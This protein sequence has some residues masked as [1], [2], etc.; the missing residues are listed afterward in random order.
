[1]YENYIENEE[2]ITKIRKTYNDTMKNLVSYPLPI[3][4]CLVNHTNIFSFHKF[5]YFKFQLEIPTIEIFKNFD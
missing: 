3:H 4:P 1:M 2:K 5:E